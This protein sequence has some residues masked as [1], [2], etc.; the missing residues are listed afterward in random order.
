MTA[1][2]QFKQLSILLVTDFIYKQKAGYL[3]LF[4][5]VLIYLND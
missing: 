1:L 2:I 3:P 5:Y 4:V